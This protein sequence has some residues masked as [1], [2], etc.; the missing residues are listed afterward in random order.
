[1]TSASNP[2]PAFVVLDA[3]I[4]VARLVLQDEFHEP[5]KKWLE[6][7]RR[8]GMQFVS[9]TLL[10]AEVAGAIARRTGD[11]ALGKKALAHLER[12]PGLRLVEMD[13]D[14]VRAAALL[15]ARLG[16]RGADSL[17]MATARQ[18]G[19]PLVTLDV[20]QRQKAQGQVTLLSIPRGR[21]SNS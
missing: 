15:A 5:V 3:S 14:L 8:D 21:G 12:L 18:L 19:L 2:G 11:P 13:H 10:L 7:E 4:W 17:Y 16:L 9:P 20:E 1:M 6:Q